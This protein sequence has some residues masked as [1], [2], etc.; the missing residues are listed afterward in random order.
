MKAVRSMFS[1][2]VKAPPDKEGLLVLQRQILK[3]IIPLYKKLHDRGL[4]ELT[5]SAY[6]HPLLPAIFDIESAKPEP[7]PARRFRRP[8]DGLAQVLAGREYFR[9][10]FGIYPRGIWP[11]EGGVSR[12]VVT[13]L[14]GAGYSFCLTDENILWKSLGSC[15]RTKLY[16][17][18]RCRDMALF[19]R[20]RELSDLL[21]FEYQRWTAEDA[22]GDFADKLGERARAAAKD[23]ICVVVL[24]GENPWEFYP[25]NGVPFLR[26][27][28][29]SLKKRKDLKPVFLADYLRGR[30]PGPEIDI[31]PGTW[32]GNF[33]KWVGHPEKNK[34]WDILWEARE[35]C[36]PLE[37]IYVAEGSDWFWWYGEEDKEEF[38][39]LFKCYIQKAYDKAGVR[40]QE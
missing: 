32:L 33:S 15:D 9:A 28:F 27:M 23:S 2:V 24:D 25:Q 35:A 7:L 37:E 17:P 39:F 40:Y 38:D 8:E 20:D 16:Q 1:P 18:Y 34:A 13:S 26:E 14:P 11:S 31:V 30:G 3:E 10:V 36:G 4:A 21:G 5:T 19:F 6:Y 29:S 22:A 12:E